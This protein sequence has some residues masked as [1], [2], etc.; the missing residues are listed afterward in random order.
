M[1]AALFVFVF[2]SLSACS[3]WT[4]ATTKED[5]IQTD[6]DLAV[7]DT[8]TPKPHHHKPK[9]TDVADSPVDSAP[10][11][12]ESPP[13]PIDAPVADAG[14]DKNIAPLVWVTLDGTNSY[15][16]G[17]LTPLNYK[18]TVVSKP[19]G[20]TVTLLL[21]STKAKPRF[22]IDIAG[23]YELKLTVQNTGRRWDPTPDHMIIN[24]VPDKR[25]Y[26]QLTWNAA[27]DLDLHFLRTGAD[28]FDRPGDCN[29]CS[30]TGNEW[31][32]PSILIDNP[33]LDFDAIN[34]YGPETTTIKEPAAGN[35]RVWVHYYGVGGAASCGG[36]C[37]RSDATL[38][39]YVDGLLVDTMNR[40]LT[41]QGQVWQAASVDWPAATI[42]HVDTIT[43]TNAT[44]C[45]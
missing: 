3:D 18:W 8:D 41:N 37:P 35:Y 6:T 12:D 17:G 14:P 4:L 23:T 24:A 22:F 13:G 43:N 44:G 11:V 34:G 21:Q 40:T 32:S 38:R 36:T 31:G 1:R 30:K 15:D 9:D 42:N 25:F 28:I 10:P 45:R 33:T 27:S 29:F 16:P 7:V 19:A 26:V 20:S 39:F 2:A 5:P